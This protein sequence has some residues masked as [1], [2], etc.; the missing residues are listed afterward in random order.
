MVTTDLDDGGRMVSGNIPGVTRETETEMREEKKKARREQ[1]KVPCIDE[2]LVVKSP[3][4]DPAEGIGWGEGEEEGKRKGGER[5]EERESWQISTSLYTSHASVSSAPALSNYW[6]YELKVSLFL[7]KLVVVGLREN[8]KTGV[9]YRYWGTWIRTQ[10]LMNFCLG[11]PCTWL[12]VHSHGD[13]GVARGRE[14]SP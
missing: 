2:L 3:V 11:S 7:L 1:E 10:I 5:E 12:P 6:M 4:R 8:R 14:M 9:G 13:W